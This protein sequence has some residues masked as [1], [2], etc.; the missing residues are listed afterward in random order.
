MWQRAELVAF[1]VGVRVIFG[2]D[3]LTALSV[4][5]FRPIDD[6]FEPAAAA[7]ARRAS[8]ASDDHVVNRNQVQGS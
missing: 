3:S 5:S 8:T 6:E 2:E 4:S 1:T 7:A